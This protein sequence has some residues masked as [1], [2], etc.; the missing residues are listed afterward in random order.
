MSS[1][2]LTAM[3]LSISRI[4]GPRTLT[5]QR[6]Y[7]SSAAS[8][9]QSL[10]NGWTFNHPSLLSLGFVDDS[11]Y[12]VTAPEPTGSLL[13]YLSDRRLE[14]KHKRK[15]TYIKIPDHGTGFNIHKWDFEDG[16]TNTASGE[17]SG[18][19]NIQNQSISYHQPEQLARIAPLQWWH[20]NLQAS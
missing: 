13:V 11:V 20:E 17:I 8:S 9:T 10:G 5:F 3:H 1:Q 7:C 6:T 2:A 18:R 19:T 15:A 14:R 12:A 16:L 4:P